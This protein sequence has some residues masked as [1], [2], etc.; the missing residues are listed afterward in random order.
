M[1]SQATGMRIV[2]KGEYIGRRGVS[3][4]EHAIRL[5]AG[6]PLTRSNTAD[7]PATESLIRASAAPIQAQEAVLLRAATAGQQ[8]PPEHLVRATGGQE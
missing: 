4:L 6:V 2:S 8:T 1:K 7:L 5:N 3:S